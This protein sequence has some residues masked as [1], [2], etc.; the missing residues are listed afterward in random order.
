MVFK[1]LAKVGKIASKGSKALKKGSKFAKKGGKKLG[2]FAKKN[3]KKALAAGAGT[4]LVGYSAVEAGVKGTNFVDELTGNVDSIGD[5]A[6]DAAKS[7]AGGMF[8]IMAKMI[9]IEPGQLKM[10]LGAVLFIWLYMTFGMFGLIAVVVMLVMF[11]YNK[12]SEYIAE[13]IPE[14]ANLIGNHRAVSG[15]TIDPFIS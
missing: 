9:G 13:N 4:G 1:A 10:G 3:P 15:G 14:L 8:D 6:G 5:A 12:G 7:A 11:L 2:K